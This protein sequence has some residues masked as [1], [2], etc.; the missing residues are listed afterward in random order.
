MKIILGESNFN[1]SHLISYMVDVLATSFC[2]FI[3]QTFDKKK[4][5]K[6]KKKNIIDGGLLQYNDSREKSGIEEKKMNTRG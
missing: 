5:E 1:K 4:K 3:S 6:K 2:H